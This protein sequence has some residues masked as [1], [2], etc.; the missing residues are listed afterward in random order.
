MKKRSWAGRIV[1]AILYLV[2]FLAVVISILWWLTKP[3]EPDAFYSVSVEMPSNPGSIIRIEPF[4]KQVPANAKGW[5]VLYTTTKF[6]GTIAPASAIVLAPKF[7]SGLP[8]NVIV[9]THGTTGVAPPC[10]PSVMA[11]PFANVPALEEAIAEG[12]ILVATDYIG[13]GTEGPHPYLIGE[14]QARS[15]LD[16]LRAVKQ[17]KEL[18]LTD[19]TVVWG[20]SQGG[21]AAMWTGIL[22]PIYASEQKIDGIA[23]AAPASDLIGLIKNAESTPVGKILSSYIITAY[24]GTYPD[25]KFDE[26]VRTG[27]RTLTRDMATRC[28]GGKEA[29]FLV[30]ESLI[31]GNTIFATDPTLGMLGSRLNENIPAGPINAPLMIAQGQIDELVLPAIQ[32]GFVEQL[33]ADGRSL[34]YV[35]YADKDHLSVVAKESPLTSDLI[36]WTRERFENK[37][38]QQGCVKTN[39]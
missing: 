9:W 20:H 39:R 15:A 12:W 21:N 6:D 28:L 4:T 37:T 26:Y 17:M 10:A 14:G 23:A 18:S 35:R 27:A 5:R 29:I 38:V 34:E 13:L 25:I 19:K 3:T 32:D 36:R 7:S 30:G 22:A 1:R 33:C 16:S 31:A 11:E 8:S 24:S 2:I